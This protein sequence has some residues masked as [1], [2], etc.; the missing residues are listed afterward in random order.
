VFG[1]YFRPYRATAWAGTVNAVRVPG[2]LSRVWSPA[3]KPTTRSPRRQLAIDAAWVISL[4]G[5]VLMTMFFDGGSIGSFW[6]ALG[7]VVGFSSAVRLRHYV[8]S[9]AFLIVVTLATW[10]TSYYASSAP[11]WATFA[12]TAL[13]VIAYLVGR[14]DDGAHSLLLQFL[15]VTVL[16]AILVP[17]LDIRLLDGVE[18]ALYLVFTIVFP[19]LVGRYRYQHAQLITA[20]WQRAE[21]L[22]REQRA[23]ADQARMRERTRIA[24]DMHDSLGHELSLI[25]LRSAALEVDAD[26]PRR[27]QE[28]AGQLRRSAAVAT[29]RLREIIGLLRDDTD[30]AS[31]TPTDESI[32]DLVDRARQSGM[33][34]VLRVEGETSALPR[35]ADR[36]A[37]RVVQESLTN[38][39]KH[40]P[41]KPVTVEVVHADGHSTVVVRNDLADIVAQDAVSGGRGLVGL[42][43]RVRLAGGTFR[44]GR[45]AERFEVSARLSHSG[46][47]L[48]AAEPAP[49]TDSALQH[50]LARR[51]ARRRLIVAFALPAGLLSGLGVIS[52]AVFYIG[53]LTA[54]LPRSEYDRL[55]VGQSQESVAEVLP[56]FDMLDPPYWYQT[57]HE[58][59][60]ADDCDYYP[61]RPELDDTSDVFRLCYLDG[62]LVHK[63]IITKEQREQHFEDSHGR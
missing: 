49:E 34:V 61:E 63:A 12:G 26:L 44:S 27:H 5:Y 42:A 38:A 43:E 29:E 17:V 54:T 10:V 2:W 7:I 20:G 13:A 24:E 25:A 6:E 3:G 18:L 53:S 62:R 21:Q 11:T 57:P 14:A 1:L 50:L 47:N 52:L 8:P 41:G 55:Y 16:I 33:D 58:V 4:S 60:T 48:A 9:A 51:H 39:A 36:A 31:V 22:E 15:A 32:A 19:W 35:M 59:A 30:T 45:V 37:H 28:A 46:E 40:A 23:V 56:P